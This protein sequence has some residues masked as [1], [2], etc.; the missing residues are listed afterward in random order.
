MNATY[1]N[2]DG[3]NSESESSFSSSEEAMLRCEGV[4]T[5]F[6]IGA[7]N[8]S[9]FTCGGNN[10]PYLCMNNSSKL[11]AYPIFEG[12]INSSEYYYFVFGSENEKIDNFFRIAFQLDKY[13]FNLPEPIP[14]CA[15]VHECHV[16]F[17]F[18]SS[19]KVSFNVFAT[20][21]LHDD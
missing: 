5:L 4:L 20:F 3:S 7:A 19:E 21:L 9:C 8:E 15:N 16:D 2:V 12:Y 14:N 10:E 13:E 18:G 1:G 17:Y 11:S 6:N